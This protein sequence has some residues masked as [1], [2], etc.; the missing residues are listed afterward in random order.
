MR[1]KVDIIVSVGDAASRAAMQATSSI[2]IVFMSGDP[3]VAG[4]AKSMSHSGTNGTGVYVP[5]T[6]LG[7]TN[8]AIDWLVSRVSSS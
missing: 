5:N 7:A 8:C 1:C 4:F 3:V 6:E 2:P